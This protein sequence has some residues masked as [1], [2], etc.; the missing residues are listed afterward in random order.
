MSTALQ[1]KTAASLLAL[2]QYAPAGATQLPSGVSNTWAAFDGTNATVSFSAPASGSAAILVTSSFQTGSNN[3]YFNIATHATVVPA[4]GG[5]IFGAS[6]GYPSVTMQF[7]I[8]GLT[9]GQTYQY[10]VIGTSAGT[11][12]TNLQCQSVF[13]PNFGYSPL[14]FQVTGL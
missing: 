12:P 8:T 2:R 10:D 1:A 7:V 9:S 11:S 13:Q 5:Y 3:A 6:S 4:A 14:T